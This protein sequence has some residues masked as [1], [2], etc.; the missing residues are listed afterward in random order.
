MKNFAL[1]M[2]F[3][4]LWANLGFGQPTAAPKI[5]DFSD[6][7]GRW[8][9]QRANQWYDTVAWPVG[10]NFVPS[11]AINQLEMWQADTF[12]PETINRE[13]GWAAAIGMNSMR[14]FLHDLAWKAD[15]EGFFQRVDKYLEIADSHGIS[16]MM[17][18]FDGVWHPYPELGKQPEP[19]P[20][21]HNSGW[22]QSPGR[23]LLED[24]TKQDSLKPYV[25]AVIRRYKDD[26]RILLWDL[27]NEPD[28]DVANSYGVNGTKEE[29]PPEEKAKRAE[30]L[31]RKTFEW[32]REVNP[33][34][35]LTCGVWAGNYL[36][37]PSSIQRFSIEASDVISFHTYSGPKVAKE[38]TQGLLKLGRPVL[39]TEY[40]A[41]GNASTFEAIL[42]IFHE[43]RVGAYNWGLVDGKSQT[44]YPWDSWSNPY[45]QE[46]KPWHHD[47]FRADGTPYSP[48]EVRVIQSLTRQP[49]TQQSQPPKIKEVPERDVLESKLKDHEEAVFV[50]QGWI[51]DPFITLG[52]DG[53]YYL[54]GTTPLP[55]D[56]RQHLDPYNTG[57]GDLSLV[58]WQAQVWRSRDLIDW[59]SLG[60]PFTLKSGI[61]FR[62]Q[63]KKF[64]NTPESEWRLWAPELH[65]IGDR[66]ALIHTSPS[67][68]AGAN[69]SLSQGAE[70]NGPWDNPMG[71][72]IRKRHDPSLFQDDDETWWMI[73]G[74]TSIAPIKPDWSGF[75]KE[76][77]K[78]GP[79]GETSKM[80][81]EGC[82]LHK[83]GDKYVLFGTG[84]STGEMRHGSY[85][86]Y[87][88]TA[89]KIEGPYSE[90]QFV[91]R[92][93]GHGT[94]FQDH[95]GRWWCTAFFNANQPPLSAEGIE[96]KDL[97][98][99]AQ[100]INEQG[101]TLVPLDVQIR[102][103]GEVSIRAEAPGYSTPGPDEAQQFQLE[104]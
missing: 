17:V 101:V 73:W 10:A 58:G 83:I 68:V 29:L 81:H 88:A 62:K 3:L 64:Q 60:T 75:Q 55:D 63:P 94:P 103:N 35:P 80:G 8:S 48:A 30:E 74:A 100:T 50:K 56:P 96:T 7:P 71:V 26:S 69:L 19:T 47:V 4:L 45:T 98:R 65:W 59:E 51:R 37:S 87:Y 27:F 91:G 38:L 40:M 57:L 72:S 95:Q 9:A 36:A 104:E 86:L 25:Q 16:T 23:K 15:P 11:T 43:N 76:P 39:C 90:R 102:D 67:P 34:Q 1:S 54:T 89:D 28:N 92:F 46:P 5:A 97:G 12:D 14:V 78:I 82:L 79:S 32:A 61:W 85:N 41:R 52:P 33:S 18:I 24:S 20:G 42:P 70:V 31:L 2:A 77:I 66:W 93:L 44:I 21:L 6:Q 99:T 84:W 13:L 22:V 53:N 49:P